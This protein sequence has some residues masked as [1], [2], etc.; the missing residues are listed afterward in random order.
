MSSSRLTFSSFAL[1]VASD[2][3]TVAAATLRAASASSR[4][5]R[6]PTLLSNTFCCRPRLTRASSALALFLSRVAF[7]SYE[8]KATLLRNKASA[9]LA[10]VNLG[11]QQKVFESK[12]G[13]RQ[14]LDEAEA[15][16][17]VAAATVELSEATIKANEENVKRLEDIQRFQ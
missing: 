2:S 17:K 11:R 10:R 8:S 1:I 12:V 9:E 4:S 16:L 7:F 5:C 13:S 15:A 14:D 3:S 6:E